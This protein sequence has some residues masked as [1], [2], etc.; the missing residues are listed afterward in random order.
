MQDDSSFSDRLD[1]Q[2]VDACLR[3]LR[4][5]QQDPTLGKENDELLPLV[6]KVYKRDR[7]ERR[8]AKGSARKAHDRNRS[9][10]AA[11]KLHEQRALSDDDIVSD[12]EFAPSENLKFGSRSCY[13]CRERYRTLHERYPWFCESCA[14]Q[15]LEKRN[16]KIDLSG[17]HIL[18]TGG[19]IK[20]GFHTALKALRGGAVVHVTSRFPK[21][22]IRRFSLEP[23]FSDWRELIL[24]HGL[25]FRNI[26]GVLA[27]C[28]ELVQSLPTL[29]IL[30]NN[31]AQSVKRSDQWMQQHQAFERGG[32]LADSLASRI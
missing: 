25:D 24:V 22:T 10:E 31:A 6:A 17:R 14:E 4:E 20:I 19:R 21:D 23:D 16:R 8:R 7:R 32:E 3:V 2:D 5:L 1:P 29:D 11:R 27:W 15:N 30:I 26:R 12:F 13:G 9:N 28:D 18:I